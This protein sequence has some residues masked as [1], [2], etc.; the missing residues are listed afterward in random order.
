MSPAS[1]Q[2]GLTLVE[3]LIALAVFA[4]LSAVAVGVLR[5]AIVAEERSAL[6]A[7][8]LSVL[9]R[10]RAII[11]A[12]FLQI[13]DRPYRQNFSSGLTPAVLGGLSA[14][15]ATETE[16]GERILMTFVRDGWANPGAREPRSTL[17]HVTYLV[18]EDDLIRRTRPFVDSVRETPTREQV[19]F[20]SVNDVVIEFFGPRG[21]IA[22]W[23]SDGGAAA[24]PAVRILFVHPALGELEQAF[25]VGAAP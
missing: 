16:S 4:V 22:D 24:L 14:E 21:W 2:R 12:D 8:E 20:E 17:Q 18:R 7:A 23:R 9:E 6:A 13:A 11:R 10:S 15:A 3:L 25:V 1:C 19:L 5:T